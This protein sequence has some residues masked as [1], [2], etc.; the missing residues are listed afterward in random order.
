M[1]MLI[2]LNST[3]STLTILHQQNRCNPLRAS[4]RTRSLVASIVTDSLNF[5]K[6]T[7]LS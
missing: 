5:P 1:H 3:Q 4:V 7:R 2:S 6:H